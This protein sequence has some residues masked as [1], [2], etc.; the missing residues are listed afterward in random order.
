MKWLQNLNL[1]DS[2]RAILAIG[3]GALLTLALLLLWY[4]A[5]PT[6]NRDA[7]MVLIGVIA[8]NVRDA[9][10]YYLGSSSGSA[11]KSATIDKFVADAQKDASAN[12]GDQP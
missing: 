10:G 5:I 7:V 4:D 9:F 2:M 8:A 6:S 3:S 11:A 12:R 1:P